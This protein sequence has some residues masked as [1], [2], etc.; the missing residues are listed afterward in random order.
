M[1]TR[2]LVWFLMMVGGAGVSIYFDFKYKDLLPF[3]LFFNVSFHVVTIIIGIV[4]LKFVLL[5]AKYTGR[6]LAKLGKKEGAKRFDVN[7]L[8]KEDI[9]SCM[10]H[11]MHLGLLFAP[12]SIALIIGSP[13]F[14][15]IVAPVEDYIEYKKQVPM[16][17]FRW[18]CLK[19]YFNNRD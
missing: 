9:Y 2:F 13:S 3:S 7:K 19:Y 18:S 1:I 12:L 8:V 15:L 16:F 10:R 6:T 5:T 14:I 4:L 17:N 11:P